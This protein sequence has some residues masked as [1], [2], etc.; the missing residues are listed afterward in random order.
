MLAIT[1]LCAFHEMYVG[2][3]WLLL[4]KEIT[5]FVIFIANSKG[6]I[7]FANGPTEYEQV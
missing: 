6:I 3:S 7:C 4:R 5:N 2:R 1:R